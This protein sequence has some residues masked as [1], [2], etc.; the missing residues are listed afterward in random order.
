MRFTLQLTTWHITPPSDADTT[1]LPR[2]FSW[3]F[4]S[5]KY[6]PNTVIMACGTIITSRLIHENL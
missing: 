6:R 3:G 5:E 2:F 4:V 1:A